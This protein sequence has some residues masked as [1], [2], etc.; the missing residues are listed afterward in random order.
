MS[1]LQ[2]MRDCSFYIQ[3]SLLNKKKKMETK[4]V[5]KFS[6]VLLSKRV[7]LKNFVEILHPDSSICLSCLRPRINTHPGDKPAMEICID[8]T[9]VGKCFPRDFFPRQDHE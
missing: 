9:A 4:Y 2:V 6:Q 3:T 8:M 1:V 5:N 7:T